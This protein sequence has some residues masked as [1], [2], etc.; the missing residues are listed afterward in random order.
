MMPLQLP[1]QRELIHVPYEH[2]RVKAG[3]CYNL[4]SELESH[5]RRHGTFLNNYQLNQATRITAGINEVC[6]VPL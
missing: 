3:S 2:L 6:S 5:W 4:E 1:D